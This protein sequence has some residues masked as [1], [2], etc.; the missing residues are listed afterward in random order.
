MIESANP[1]P[2]RII[3]NL[4]ANTDYLSA[5]YSTVFC[6]YPNVDQSSDFN[7]IRQMLDET[8]AAIRDGYRSSSRLPLLAMMRFRLWMC[9]STE[10]LRSVLDYGTMMN[11]Q[12]FTME[13]ATSVRYL[14]SANAQEPDVTARLLRHF[15]VLRMPAIASDGILTGVS[16]AVRDFL[17]IDDADTVASALCSLLDE[18]EFQYRFNFSHLLTLI[19]RTAMVMDNRRRSTLPLA[20]GFEATAVLYDVT[21]SADTLSAVDRCVSKVATALGFDHSTKMAEVA[22]SRQLSNLG[23]PHFRPVTS[24]SEIAKEC[25]RHI[26]AAQ[27][28][29]FKVQ[30]EQQ[31]SRFLENFDGAQVIVPPCDL[32]LEDQQEMLRISRLFTTPRAHVLLS[33]DLNSLAETIVSATT[34]LLNFPLTVFQPGAPLLRTIHDGFVAAGRSETHTV[35]L[36]AEQQLNEDDLELV[37][38]MVASPDVF[39][40]FASNEILLLMSE[41]H[42]SE[43]DEDPFH[44]ETLESK[45]QYPTLVRNFLRNCSHFFH[46]CV[47]APATSASFEFFFNHCSTLTLER[48]L[49]AQITRDLGSVQEYGSDFGEVAMQ[50]LQKLIEKHPTLATVPLLRSIGVFFDEIYNLTKSQYEE[51]YETLL[52]L[53]EI[54]RSVEETLD[55]TLKRQIAMENEVEAIAAE[56]ALSVE[57]TRTAGERALLE[58]EK[59]CEEAEQ[60]KEQQNRAEE[61]RKESEAALAKTKSLL[62]QTTQELRQL[63]SRDISVIR[64]M[65]HPPRGVFLVVKSIVVIMGYPIEDP[66]DEPSG[67]QPSFLL[68]RK[69]LSDPSCVQNLM[70]KALEGLTDSIIDLLSPLIKDPNFEP[71]L[72]AKSSTAAQSICRFVHAIVPYYKAVKS[73]GSRHEQFTEFQDMVRKLEEQHALASQRL[74]AMNKEVEDLDAKSKLLLLNKFRLEAQLEA[75]RANVDRNRSA[76]VLMK[77]FFDEWAIEMNDISTKRKTLESRTFFFATVLAVF[78][79]AP[80]NERDSLFEIVSEAFERNGKPILETRAK[81]ADHLARDLPLSPGKYGESLLSHS[82]ENF[83]LL[84]FAKRKWFF[85][86]DPDHQVLSFLR[87]YA[88]RP[89]IT[90]YLSADFEKE[91]QTAILR[92]DLLLIYD[93]DPAAKSPRLY[94]TLGKRGKP[95]TIDIA[96]QHLEV[97]ED[98]QIAFIVDAFPETPL[99]ESVFIDLEVLNEEIEMDIAGDVFTFLD[100]DRAQAML[101]ALKSVSDSEAELKRTRY[102]LQGVLLTCEQSLLDDERVYRQFVA[103][104]NVY[105]RL[106]SQVARLQENRDDVRS[107]FAQVRELSKP[108]PDLYHSLK[109]RSGFRAFHDVFISILTTQQSGGTPSSQVKKVLDDIRRVLTVSAILPLP[110]EARVRA[111]CKIGGIEITGFKETIDSVVEKFGESVLCDPATIPA[112]T[113]RSTNRRPLILNGSYVLLKYL[114]ASDRVILCSI[115]RCLAGFNEALGSGKGLATILA[116]VSQIRYLLAVVSKMQSAASLSADFRFYVFSNFPP[117]DI[118][119]P[120]RLL[121]FCDLLDTHNLLS[122]RNHLSFALSSL[123][124]PVYDSAPKRAP[125]WRRIILLLAYFDA[126]ANFMTQTLFQNVEFHEDRLSHMIHYFREYENPRFADLGRL[127]VAT[128]YAVEQPQMELNLWRIWKNLF[129]EDNLALTPV[130]VFDAYQLP[131]TYTPDRAAAIPASWPLVD[132]ALAYGL[133]RDSEQHFEQFSIRQWR[134][135]DFGQLTVASFELEPVDPSDAVWFMRAEAE[136]VDRRFRHGQTEFDRGLRIL[137]EKLREKSTVVDLSVMFAPK[138]FF[139]ILRYDFVKRTRC[140]PGEVGMLLTLEKT[141]IGIENLIIINADCDDDGRFLYLSGSRKLRQVFLKVVKVEPEMAPIYLYRRGTNIGTFMVY[142]KNVLPIDSVFCLTAFTVLP[143]GAPRR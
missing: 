75:Q 2:S 46:I 17:A 22:G 71:S 38:S 131:G 67:T 115:T 100:S 31:E 138:V 107:H 132:R 120:S 123:P 36:V 51:R 104:S 53:S 126:C 129:T 83:A 18:V 7:P 20:L 35:L 27:S 26:S 102:D 96:G 121:C 16:R 106:N 124:A 70:K 87:P 101:S 13:T 98:F 1:K 80:K 128:F 114:T 73:F 21:R 39:G 24:L 119:F 130:S 34:S 56:I 44:E 59:V 57:Q 32:V 140:H 12:T 68:G 112:L 5:H 48:P 77:R 49:Q 25:S 91:L 42:C 28:S 40:L 74:A 66:T 4:V 79:T 99:F 63:S 43:I 93:Y 135:S 54:C 58:R 6:Q 141:E 64:T 45:A 89:I 86:I 41:I 9:R 109:P 122:I 143:K 33:T 60:L 90:S 127:A 11:L 81:L 3:C 111:L 84:Y 103:A 118:G 88:K 85:V 113:D 108:F 82:V 30:P 62:T 134:D 47:V 139:E 117:S 8:L 23:M 142:P 76:A 69:L 72:V 110:I 105:S 92:N 50:T 37:K 29:A 78:G 116:D 94:E 95:V 136:E 65:N 19:Q 52:R 10:L 55:G 125:I 15:S 137:L 61:I 133:P 97:P 14:I